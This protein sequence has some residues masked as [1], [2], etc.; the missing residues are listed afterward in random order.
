MP[1]EL[2]DRTV[3]LCLPPPPLLSPPLYRSGEAIPRWRSEDAFSFISL[4]CTVTHARIIL[5][6]LIAQTF[7]RENVTLPTANRRES[8]IL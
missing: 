6:I 1:V 5:L 3:W 8:E 2:P 4:L 7:E